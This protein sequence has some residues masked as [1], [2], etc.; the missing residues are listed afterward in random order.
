MSIEKIET[1]KEQMELTSHIRSIQG[2]S[3]KGSEAIDQHIWFKSYVE[4]EELLDDE[5]FKEFLEKLVPSDKSYRHDQTWGEKNAQSHIRSAL[6]KP[7][8]TVP[9]EG[10]KLVLGTWQQIILVDFDTRAR[11]REI[12]VQI[13]GK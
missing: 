6:I 11:E 12:T 3:R 5:D 13:V 7:F 2:L 10:G 4:L 9:I 8:L 1:L